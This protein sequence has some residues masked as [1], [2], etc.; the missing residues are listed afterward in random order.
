MSTLNAILSDITVQFTYNETY[1]HIF[2]RVSLE[3][4]CKTAEG[5]Y[6]NKEKTQTV[7]DAFGKTYQFD[8]F[9]GH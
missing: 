9:Y 7:P 1:I 5:Q 6:Q 2:W 8:S 4:F 3:K